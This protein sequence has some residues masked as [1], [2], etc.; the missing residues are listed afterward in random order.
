M[1]NTADFS[2]GN[3]YKHIIRLA[4]PMILAQLVQMVYNIVDRI[5]IGHL[6]DVSTI[7]LAGIGLTTPIITI[8][9]AFTNLFGMGGSP[10]FSIELGKKNQDEAQKILGNTFTLLIGSSFILMLILYCFMKP[11]LFRLGASEVSYQYA[12]SYLSIYLIGTPFIM[13]SSG[14][15]GFINA[16]GFSKTGMMTVTIGAICN[17]FL[18]PFFIYTLNMGIQGAAIATI[19]SQSISFIWVMLF[20]MNK[21]KGI[22]LSKDSLKLNLSMDFNIVSLGMAG[23]V[24]QITNSIFQA[25]VINTIKDYG[26]DVYIGIMTIF[27]S[28]REMF[29]LPIIGLCHACQPIIGFNYGAKCY[30][31]IKKTIIFVT[32]VGFIFMIS[33][34]ILMRIYPEQI[35]LLFNED[36][37]LLDISVHS[38]KIYFGGFFMMTF[39][40]AGQSTFT[41][42]GKAKQS[43]FFSIFRK[44]IL[45]VPL[46]L[47]LPT[48]LGI[49]GIFYAE[50]ISN[51]V[52]GLASY[53]TMLYITHK[54]GI[55]K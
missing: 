54:E 36:T 49:D 35:I 27:N 40:S 46:T 12:S 47:I 37:S 44:I 31:R 53:C 33:V 1:N 21:K 38:L 17:I 6:S 16:Q 20:L 52:G 28:V 5:Y 23:F 41:A 32:I 45:V 10:L 29:S 50:P 13:I 18:D 34:W 4:I 14:M 25:V 11:I 48:F 55:W 24:V 3:I 51:Y 39:Q 22:P 15:N 9:M 19:L 30:D 2:K 42:L 43:I 26:G 8:I 7:A